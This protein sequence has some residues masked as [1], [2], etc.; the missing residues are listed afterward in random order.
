MKPV[1]EEVRFEIA[2]IG[3]LLRRFFFLGML[4]AGGAIAGCGGSSNG[5]D[6]IIPPED[7]CPDPGLGISVGGVKGSAD[8]SVTPGRR[9]V[10]MGGGSEH[11]D[12]S[13]RFLEGASGGD[14]VI[15]R[16]SGSLTSY[17]TYFTQ[18]LSPTPS[19]SSAVTVLTEVPTSG[20]DPS[21]L[22]WTSMAEA[23]WLA[24]GDQW[25]YLGLWPQPLHTALSQLNARGG[26]LGGTSAGAAS[27]GEA[28]FDAEYGTVTSAEALADP[29]HAEVSLSYPSFSPSEL[30][31]VL[32]DSHF[33]DRG[34]EG[35]LL[36]FL[37]RFLAEKSRGEVVGIGLDERVAVV[38]QGGSYRVYAPPGQSAWLYRVTGPSQLEAGAPLE[39]AGIE[40]VRLDHD[41][42]G[43]WPVDFGS[44]VPTLLRVQG[45]VV[46]VVE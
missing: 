7:R 44:F 36:A 15:L 8:V 34:R 38:I 6:P 31:G 39:L 10:L 33:S 45:G 14:V 46:E 41:A 27:L 17:P 42:Q 19:P 9:I 30:Q 12:A 13:T 21:V 37:A 16:A 23:V 4:S 28:A 40:R 25:S 2:R 24:G 35:R 18:T 20:D 26:A 5:L 43:P 32:V 29:L 1:A 22:C 3:F 11:D